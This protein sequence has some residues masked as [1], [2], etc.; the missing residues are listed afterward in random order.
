MDLWTRDK[1]H[2]QK[3]A[4][5]SVDGF[6]TTRKSG[7]GGVDGRI[8]FPMPGKVGLQSMAVEVK[9]GRNVGIGVMRELRGVLD[10]DAAQLAGLIVMEPPGAAKER[11][12]K[13]FMAG[14]GHLEVNGMEYPRLQVLTVKEVLDG[15]RFKTPGVAARGI[16]QKSLELPDQFA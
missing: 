13:K 5:E 7:D 10:D 11:N 1:Y 8:Y 16:G 6:V 2:F 9:G 14:A 4:V 3:W 15:R 12:F